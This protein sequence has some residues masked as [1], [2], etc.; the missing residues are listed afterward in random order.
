MYDLVYAC[1]AV[2]VL[3]VVAMV[4]IM[5]YA[6]D[7]VS[8][9]HKPDAAQPQRVERRV[10]APTQAPVKT[11]PQTA[12]EQLVAMEPVEPEVNMDALAAATEAGY[13]AL[14]MEHGD[15]K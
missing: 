15:S 9:C 11:I 6:V 8:R 13:A 2:I 14:M 12:P 3:C 5:R 10:Q 1:L 4:F 7:A